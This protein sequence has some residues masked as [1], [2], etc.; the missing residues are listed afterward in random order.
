MPKTKWYRERTYPSEW[1]AKDVA[2]YWKK[3]RGQSKITKTKT[4]WTVWSALGKGRRY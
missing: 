4:G 2:K 3:K 1:Y